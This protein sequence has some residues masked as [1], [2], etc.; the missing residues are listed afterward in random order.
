MNPLSLIPTAWL[1]PVA[2]VV[3][4]AMAGAIGVQ[5][6]RLNSVRDELKEVMRVWNAEHLANTRSALI[7][8]AANRAEE[9]RRTAAQ[10]EVNSEAERLSIRSRDAAVR[11]AAA[12]AGLRQRAA[13]FAAACDRAAGDSPSPSE[14]AP[15][16][17]PGAVLAD[18][19][20]RL[21]AAGRELAAEADRRGIAGSAC[22]RSYEAL[23]APSQ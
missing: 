19:L 4:L 17:G 3:G 20:G 16:A 6:L 12:G 5:T 11:A 10:Q 9:R 18:V 8:T 21:E 7:A 1:W 14:R 15:A 13:P 2:G 23:T 22:Q